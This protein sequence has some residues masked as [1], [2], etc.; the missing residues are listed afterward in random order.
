MTLF[1]RYNY[2]RN[3]SQIRI[4]SKEIAF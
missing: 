1:K 2:L 4:I 3:Y